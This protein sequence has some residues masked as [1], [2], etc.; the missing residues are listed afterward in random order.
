M[1]VPDGCQ[2][3]WHA[4]PFGSLNTWI[5]FPESG[6]HKRTVRSSDVVAIT[7]PS[8][9]KLKTFILKMFIYLCNY[10]WYQTFLNIISTTILIFKSFKIWTQ[11]TYRAHRTQFVWPANDLTNLWDCCPFRTTVHSFA[12][13]SSEAVR[14][15]KISNKN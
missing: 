13:L 15:L 3:R 12:L 14:T 5:S 11:S 2:S 7:S 9:E 4:N 1:Q 8:G 6:S 10:W